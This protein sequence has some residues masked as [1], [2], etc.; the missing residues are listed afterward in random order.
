MRLE[1][2]IRDICK[3][4]EN[5]ELLSKIF[6]ELYKFIDTYNFKGAC[7][8][9]ASIMYVL[10]SETGFSPKI[11]LGEIELNEYTTFDHSWIELN[12]KIIDIAI[13]YPLQPYFVSNPI[14][15]N[16]DVISQ[17]FTDLKYGIRKNGIDQQ[18][19]YILQTNLMDYMN[20]SPNF[21]GG[22][23]FVVQQISNALNLGINTQNIK[24]KYQSTKWHFIEKDF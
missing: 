6:L 12:G 17:T 21:E 1:E 8:E 4:I 2:N 20:N 16:I 15:L 10:L 18:S 13:A 7:H 9:T 5:G 23:W 24:Q 3:N 19:E 14:L 11:C 22:S